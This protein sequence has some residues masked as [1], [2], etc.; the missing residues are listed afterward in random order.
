MIS[1]AAEWPSGQMQMTTMITRERLGRR[2][3]FRR[4][5]LT[6]IAI[7]AISLAAAQPAAAEL[8][9]VADVPLHIHAFDVAAA[10][11]D[12]DGNVDLALPDQDHAVTILHGRGD[13]S[14]APA[15]SLRAGAIPHHLQIADLN[16]DGRKDI[17]V[18][19]LEGD[20]ISVFL[21]RTK[22]GFRPAANYR[23]GDRPSGVAV[24][25][26]NH[27]RWP[28]LAVSNAWDDDVSVQLGTGRGEFG[29]RRDYRTGNNPN[30]VAIADFNGDGR[31]DLTIAD[32]YRPA[33]L[34]G[35]GDGTFKRRRYIR[36]GIHFTLA[37]VIA[38]RVDRDRLPDLLATS[39]N[40]DDAQGEWLFL[41]RGDGTFRHP[42]HYGCIYGSPTK[43]AVT[44]IT[45]DGRKDMVVES[46][47][48]YAGGPGRL[49]VLRGTRYGAFTYANYM[50][51]TLD[52]RGG[53][54]AIADFDADGDRDIAAVAYGP[55]PKLEIFL[56]E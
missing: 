34:E 48:D 19:N 8:V 18:T 2:T 37:D 55:G 53:R 11:F 16:R 7:A 3:G 28:D 23:V 4:A 27:D 47:G 20:S 9:R 17:V 52:G 41:G 24:G 43:T 14:F 1:K 35:R 44:D 50:A 51:A 54:F 46:A 12:R 33:I 32:I 10:D 5:A 21:G 25:R 30:S 36:T 40:N 6:G 15:G 13:G 45:G 26:L 38:A 56:N 31:R 42:T 22:G 29:R 39:I 49:C